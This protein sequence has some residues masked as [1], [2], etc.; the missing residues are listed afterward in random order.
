MSLA[1]PPDAPATSNSRLG[2][3]NAEKVAQARLERK[4]AQ[5]AKKAGGAKVKGSGSDESEDENDNRK[6]GKMMK[7][8]D[9]GAPREMSRRERSVVSLLFLRLLTDAVYSEQADKAAAKERYAK[10]HAA[11]K[12]ILILRHQDSRI[13]ISIRRR[14]TR[15][16]QISVD[17]P[18]FANNE[19]SPPLN[20]SPKQPVSLSVS[21]RD[22]CS[23]LIFER[24][25][26]GG[27]VESC[28]GEVGEEGAVAT[29]DGGRREGVEI[30]LH[31]VI[32][33]SRFY[34]FP[35]SATTLCFRIVELRGNAMN[36]QR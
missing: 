26:Q 25:S 32:R 9:L 34:S 4:M 17:S 16:E 30:V 12:V 36:S 35:I 1:P 3:M 8:A 20:E 22:D 23:L 11:G 5:G 13:D 27:F 33:D 31:F 29:I 2:A 14:R 19:N 28:V 24:Y 7:A 18:P 15:R 21:L 10:L 6:A